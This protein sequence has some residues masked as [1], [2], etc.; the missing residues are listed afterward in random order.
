MTEPH[1][2]RPS[3]MCTECGLDGAHGNHHRPCPLVMSF[4]PGFAFCQL[5]DDHPM[6][7]RLKDWDGSIWEYDGN[8]SKRVESPTNEW[9]LLEY[10]KNTPPLG[11]LYEGPTDD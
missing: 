7:H 9:P 8:E 3:Q 2:Y 4:G 5:P 6:P 10:M 1:W 11:S